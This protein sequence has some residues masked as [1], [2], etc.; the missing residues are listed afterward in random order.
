MKKQIKILHLLPSNSFSGAENVVCNI[1]ENNKK[2]DMYYCCPKCPI[3]EVLKEK[4]IQY[5]P[6]D[7]FD[8]KHL[9]S[10]IKKY[11]IDIIH[12]HDF[13]ASFLA[14]MINF[15][16]K[17]ISHLHNNP[18]FIRKINIFTIFYSIV[19]KKF[20]KVAL[21]SNAVYEDAIFKKKIKNKYVIITNVV[22]KNNI[23]KLSEEKYNK[24]YDI[25]F[26]GRITEQKNPFLFINIINE[27][28]KTYPKVKTAMIGDGD[29]YNNCLKKIEEKKLGKN[30]DMLKFQKNPF[31]ILK[32]CNFVI[33][34]SIFEGFG[35]TAIES[36]CLNKP[37]LNS[38]EGGLK[39]I[40]KND[41]NFIC[42]DI[43]SYVEKSLNLL[44]D[45]DKYRNY[46]KRCE[47]II[48]PYV[49]IE[50]WMNNIYSL[51]EE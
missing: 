20:H 10:I 40:F 3:Q 28:K 6:I 16:G 39:V 50:K 24:K 37:V 29:L 45:K 33:M 42:K 48:K 7:K 23:I 31:K 21:V 22:N 9:K 38:G 25:I 49:D 2:Y 46:Q 15:K 26:I 18:P 8:K 47:C 12:A 32:K 51:Y 35:L 41:K 17:I 5:I 43:N 14:G 13:K 27:I 34:P 11:N 19:C 44:N 30:I 4:K 36:M 1:I